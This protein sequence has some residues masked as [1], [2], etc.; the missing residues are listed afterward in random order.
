MVKGCIFVSVCLCLSLLAG[1]GAAGT[2][3]PPNS[4]SGGSG[5]GSD[6]PPALS[7]L[8]VRSRVLLG[9]TQKFT[10]SED[11]TWAVNGVA[12]GNDIVGTISS[13][14]LYTAPVVV[15]FDS[16]ITITAT[17][18][19]HGSTSSVRAEVGA[20]TGT[21]F[22]YVSSATDNSI[23]IFTADE[24]TG[25]LQPTSILSMGAGTAPTALAVSPNG[26]FLLSLNRGSNDISIY[27]IDAATGNLANAGTVPVPS[28]PYAMVFSSKG[29]F[30]Y[31]SCDGA[32]TVAAFAFSVATGALTQ[33]SSGSYVAGG[34]RIQSLAISPD[35]K[36]LYAVNRDANQIIG[37]AIAADG[38]LSSIAGSPFSAQPGLSSI[39]VNYSGD[40]PYLYA[41]SD[42]GIEAY[43]R[44]V[45]SG[46]L[47][48][49]PSATQ[50]AAGKSPELFRNVSDGLLIGVNPQS[51][52]GFS[53]AFDYLGLPPG[54]LSVGGPAVSTGTSPGAGGWLWSADGFVNWVFVLNRQADPS[55]T[56]GSIGVYQV[57]YTHGLV[58]PS[59][60]IATELHNPTGLAAISH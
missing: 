47:T 37:L 29:D 20:L 27:A 48:Y 45:K 11:V 49:L 38:S 26:K 36:F 24:K 25:R 59:A 31:V 44:N 28:G 41:G 39:A 52:G 50:T 33:L 5:S 43:D 19:A 2:A 7:V 54:A 13:A 3:D 8:P 46:G 6:V 35:G 57:D 30:A 12:G 17:S 56:T 18:K 34:G 16:V 15:P 9:G 51:G 55:S 14:G 40:Y 10:S 23:Q 4:S 1:C 60:T 42:N 22:A 53:Y 32:S 21:R 58:G